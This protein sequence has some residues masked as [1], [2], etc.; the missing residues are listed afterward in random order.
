MEEEEEEVTPVDIEVTTQLSRPKYR[1]LIQQWFKASE[2]LPVDKDGAITAARTLLESS[3]KLILDELSETYDA[4]ADLPKLY[5]QASSKL[6]ISAASHIDRI[7]KSIFGSVHNIVQNVGELRNKAGDSH[8]KGKDAIIVSS[9]QAQLA[10][11]LAGSISAFLIATLEAYIA[12][13]KRLDANGNA[14]LRFDKTTIWRLRDHAKNAPESKKAYSWDE[15]KPVPALWLVGDS[16]LYLMS[17]GSPPI[18]DTGE[19]LKGTY[20]PGKVKFLSAKAQGCDPS[21]DDVESWWPL[22]NAVDEGNDFVQPI[23]LE[24]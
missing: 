12:A 20:E 6:G 2:R 11:N 10:V 9:A 8:G 1:S 18:L 19:V 24:H 22:Q 15:E 23:P 3:C 17:N 7:L 16:G 5:T 21:V 14:V 13:T 4:S